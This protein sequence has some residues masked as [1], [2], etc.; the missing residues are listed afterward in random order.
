MK[1]LT[2]DGYKNFHSVM[3]KYSKSV[4]V[5]FKGGET[6]GCSE[7]HKFKS[8]NGEWV[9][10]RDL[11]SGDELI[12]I[13]GGNFIVDRIEDNGIKV[14][15]TPVGVENGEYIS[16]GL[17]NKNCSFLGSTSTL[18]DSNSLSALSSKEPIE[19]KYGYDLKI[20]EE[21]EEGALYVMGVDTAVGTG[22]DYSAIQVLRIRK[23]NLYEQVAVYKRNTIPVDD[24]AQIV[25]DI[26]M[27]YNEALFIIENND[28][29]LLAVNKL[30]YDIG[31][32]TMLN[33]DSNTASLGTKATRKSKLEAC[34]LLKS[35]VEKKRLIIND[36]DT[37]NQLSRYEEVSPNVFRGAKGQN[38]DLVSALYWSVY[39]INQPEIDLDSLT[40]R[41]KNPDE[42]DEDNLPLVFMTGF[43][44]SNN[45]IK[46]SVENFWDDFN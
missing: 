45:Y 17:V 27:W 42:N 24:Y 4:I 6:K 10:A 33:T 30:F 14:V 34:K 8:I 15:Y 32:E 28:I 46:D 19:Y 5:Y 41:E 25:H 21:P 37:I 40:V 35:A 39:C 11:K 31:N 2:R 9:E 18:I 1:I 16:S 43:G 36:Y 7:D 29:G 13:S 26:S 22:G 44:D 23:K 12:N 3:K 38:D 20:F